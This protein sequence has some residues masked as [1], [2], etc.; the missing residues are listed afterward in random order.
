MRTIWSQRV[1]TAMQ[2]CP[3]R[4]GAKWS[5]MM[6]TTGGP[7]TERPKPHVPSSAVTTQAGRFQEAGSVQERSRR[8]R[9]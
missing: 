1:S 2:S 4:F 6:E 7:W 5:L 3:T 9:S 8:K